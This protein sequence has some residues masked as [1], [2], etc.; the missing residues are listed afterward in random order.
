MNNLKY[1]SWIDECILG[2][3][4]EE[5]VAALEEIER[6]ELENSS[7]NF[8]SENNV[9][10]QNSEDD[11]SIVFPGQEENSARTNKNKGVGQG[12]KKTGLKGSSAGGKYFFDI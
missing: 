8:D 7:D 5:L 6:E 2:T 12:K 11:G 9:E 10:D 1:K 4:L 3:S